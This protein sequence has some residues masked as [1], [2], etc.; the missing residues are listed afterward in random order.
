M[1]IKQLFI[2]FLKD[3]N[4]YNKFVNNVINYNYVE[5]Y[6]NDPVVAP[7]NTHN[8]CKFYRQC[9]FLPLC[10]QSKEQRAETINNEMIIDE[11]NPL[12]E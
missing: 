9:N 12:D 8:C 2:Q 4:S 5:E 7:M 1:N 10:V 3:N 11:W 6:K